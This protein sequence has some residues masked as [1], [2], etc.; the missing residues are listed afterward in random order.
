MKF[1][2]FIVSDHGNGGCSRGLIY[3]NERKA[4]HACGTLP[5]PNVAENFKDIWHFPSIV[6][7][8]VSSKEIK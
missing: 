3:G 1:K 8:I 5:L 6:P 2:Q 7:G 4:I